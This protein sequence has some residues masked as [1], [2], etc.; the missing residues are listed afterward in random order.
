M[1]IRVLPIA[2]LLAL[3]TGCA[4]LPSWIPGSRSAPARLEASEVPAA[5]ERA[6]GDLAAGRTRSALDWMRAAGAAK[7]LDTATRDHV[8]R[9]LEQAA[10]KRIAE[11]SEPGQDPEDLAD[12]VEL[13]LPRQIAVQAG[14]AA[15]RRLIEQGERMDA[16]RLLRKLDKK[17][18]L[19]HEHRA[20][21]DLMDEIGLALSREKRSFL[22]FWSTDA[23]AEEVLEYALLNH[24]SARQD[25]LAHLRLA[26][27]YEEHDD[28]DLAID[29]LEKLVLNHPDSALRPQA[30]AHIPEL[31]LALLRSPEY[32]RG[33]L[34]KAEAEL[35]RWLKSFPGHELE[36][37][38]GL[39]LADC[40]RRLCD[41]D[42][43]IAAF[44]RRVNNSYGARYHA[45]RAVDEARGGADEQRAARAQAIVD[46]L[47][48]EPAAAP[49]AAP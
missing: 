47:P 8:Q 11:L 49:G 7:G 16:Y 3:L 40:L 46:A 5:I 23:Q 24:P 18:P 4:A 10:Q 28:L 38:V 32:D 2:L 37:R 25:D 27:L 12:L 42:L 33:T 36:R 34:L 43:A 22:F 14:L 1:N 31:R 44:Y 17:F 45:Q 41:N 39:D 15:A 29:R 35:E 20:A 19:H 26:E 6:E 48:V 21:G 30:Q 9:V 13:G